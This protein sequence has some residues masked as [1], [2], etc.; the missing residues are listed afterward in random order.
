MKAYCINL[1]RRPDR[2]T[3]IQ[4]EFAKAGIPFERIS[5]VDG[6]DPQVAAAAAR[7]P[8]SFQNVRI[9]TGAHGCMQSHRLFWKRLL[10][11]G[12]QWGLIFE[13]D[14]LLAQ[15]MEGLLADDWPPQDAD[16]VK[17]ETYLIR[18]QVSAVQKP[19]GNGRNVAQL[20]SSHLGTG[21]YA[22]SAKAAARALAATEVCGEAVDQFLF[23]Q[24]LPFFQSSRVYQMIPAPVIQG[25]KAMPG[26]EKQ[27]SGWQATSI[28][29]RHAQGEAIEAGSRL[30]NFARV[31][32]RLHQ[33]LTA[34]MNGRRYSLVPHG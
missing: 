1:D 29:Q 18:L 21:S 26:R 24:T 20:F 23:N 19:V 17:L 27:S 2:L 15:G 28:T 32:H 13:D 30:S 7:L 34:R 12:D 25:D 16:I 14:L 3:H 8:M 10:A 9:S 4:S 31:K 11:S 6:T 22:I 33:E 5:A